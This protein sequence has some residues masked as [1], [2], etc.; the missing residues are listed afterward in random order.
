[1]EN[2]IAP[3]DVQVG[4]VSCDDVIAR[5]PAFGD[6]LRGLLRK[7]SEMVMEK[8]LVYEPKTT[9]RVGWRVKVPRF[10]ARRFL[11]ANEPRGFPEV[12]LL[13]R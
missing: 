1:M 10:L 13:I 9:T 5:A 4:L 7:D 8:P 11:R 2:R 12:W 3:V 6:V